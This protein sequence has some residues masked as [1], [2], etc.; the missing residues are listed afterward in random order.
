LCEVAVS[1]EALLLLQQAIDHGLPPRIALGME[2][3]PDFHSLQGDPRFA[4]WSHTPK[5]ALLRKR[6]SSVRIAERHYN[7]WVR[8]RQEQF[9]SS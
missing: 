6:R 9:G 4:A 5:R 8:S 1:G 3:E 2:H 7:P